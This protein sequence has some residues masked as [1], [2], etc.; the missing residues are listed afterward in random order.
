[1]FSVGFDELERLLEDS[2][3]EVEAAEAHGCLAGALCA[4]APYGLDQW[5][6]EILPD[7]EVRRL[8]PSSRSA[9]AAIFTETAQAMTGIDMGF[10]PLL[11]DDDAALPSRVAGL[12]QW[13][14]GFLY[15]LGL[16]SPVSFE[17]MPGD[18][19]EILRDFS[20]ISRAEVDS[21]EPAESGE[22]AYAELLEFVRAGAQLVFEE[23]ADMR[24][25]VVP[26]DARLH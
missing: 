10:E 16:G 1:M 12:A 13:C 14:H 5:I 15:G 6:D 8:V 23:L 7:D 25:S 20:E 4:T 21:G 26:T 2:D 3:A 17:R 18:V 9:F 11:P 22:A 19:G 24:R